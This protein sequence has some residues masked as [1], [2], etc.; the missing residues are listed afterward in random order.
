MRTEYHWILADYV[1][2]GK[3]PIYV[4]LTPR[5]EHPSRFFHDHECS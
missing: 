3:L 2:P 5:G 4:S 1:Q